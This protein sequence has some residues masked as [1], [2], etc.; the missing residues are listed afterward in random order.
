LAAKNSYSNSVVLSGSFYCPNGEFGIRSSDGFK[1]DGKFAQL[2]VATIGSVVMYTK[3]LYRS[4]L[5]S[6]GNWQSGWAK[7]S[8]KYEESTGIAALM[9]PDDRSLH[10]IRPPGF[11][12]LVVMI[13]GVEHFELDNSSE[14]T[15]KF[16]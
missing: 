13:N 8:Y 6:W 16:E 2:R 4:G 1:K 3:G 15:Y 10:G 7:I 14:W 9:A 5:T 11:K 12:Q